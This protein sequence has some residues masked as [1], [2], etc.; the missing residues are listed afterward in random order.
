MAACVMRVMIVT[1]LIAFGL[2]GDASIA[3]P[4]TNVRIL[5]DSDAQTYKQ[6][7]AAAGVGD[8]AKVADRKSVV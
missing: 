8:K 2:A 1:A 3:A 4:S 7:F 6:M 5:S